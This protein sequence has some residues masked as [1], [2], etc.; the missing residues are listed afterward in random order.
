MKQTEVMEVDLRSVCTLQALN[1]NFAGV[2]GYTTFKCPP[3]AEEIRALN[4][5]APDLVVP[6]V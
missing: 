5:A 6:V 2:V 1:T 3:R 4:G